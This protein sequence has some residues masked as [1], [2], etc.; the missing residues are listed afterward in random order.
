VGYR[1]DRK[2]ANLKPRCAS[3]RGFSWRREEKEGAAHG[4]GWGAALPV[5]RLAK[6][7]T[8]RG[9]YRG[10]VRGSCPDVMLRRAAKN[11][12][13]GVHA[14]TPQMACRGLC[15]CRRLVAACT[16]LGVLD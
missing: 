4:I 11:N 15:I 7:K 2:S 12:S 8:T 14:K 6:P 5:L 3:S 10:V 9:G 16:E 13:D 1:G